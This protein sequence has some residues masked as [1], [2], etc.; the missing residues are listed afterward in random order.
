MANKMM[1]I[2]NCPTCNAKLHPIFEGNSNEFIRHWRCTH[3]SINWSLDDLEFKPVQKKLDKWMK[4][5]G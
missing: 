3:C 2:E 4:K 1:I 5:N